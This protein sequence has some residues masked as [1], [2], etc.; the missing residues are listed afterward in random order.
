MKMFFKKKVKPVI[1]KNPFCIISK[2][3]HAKLIIKEDG[4]EYFYL[5]L[6]EEWILWEKGNDLISSYKYI[7]WF[8]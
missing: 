3:G 5:R 8:A 6:D 2:D 7:G 1:E 4:L